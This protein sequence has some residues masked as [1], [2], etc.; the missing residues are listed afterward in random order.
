MPNEPT[1]FVPV[2]FKKVGIAL[3]IIGLALLLYRLGSIITKSYTVS[4]YVV[5]IGTVLV[6]LGMYFARI[7][8]KS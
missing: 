8:P 1:G 2:K 3:F 7:V 6:L 4:N 5:Y